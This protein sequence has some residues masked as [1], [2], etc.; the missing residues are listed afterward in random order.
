MSIRRIRV[1]PD[2]ILRKKCRVVRRVDDKVRELAYDMIETMDAASGVGL[3]AN[4]VGAL[5]RVVTLHL[6]G[7]ED[8]IILI[9][10]EIRDTEGEREIIEGCL[11]F[12]GYEG[13]VKRSVSVKARWLD[14]NGSKMKVTTEDLFAQV[15]EHEVDHLNG[16]LYID[17][18]LEHEKLDAAGTHVEEGEPHMHDIEV[19]VHADHSDDDEVEPQESDIEVVHTTIKFNDLYS[20]SLVD[21]M[22]YDLRKAGYALPP[23]ESE[24]GDRVESDDPHLD[25]GVILDPEHKH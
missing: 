23:S 22:H 1:F 11:S 17:H 19:E 16:I 21:Q 13:M 15:L 3:A 8:A 24:A 4:Q 20:E 7:D 10:P 12:P 14:E 18:L 25:G 6:P 5:Q 2:P 9:N